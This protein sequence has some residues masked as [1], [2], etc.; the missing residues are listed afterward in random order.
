[1]L[2]FSLAFRFSDLELPL[3]AAKPSSPEPFHSPSA[4]AAWDI[5]G[6]RA[7]ITQATSS[8]FITEILVDSGR[9]AGAKHHGAGRILASSTKSGVNIC[10]SACV[11]G[12]LRPVVQHHGVACLGEKQPAL[13]ENAE[14]AAQQSQ[15]R[16]QQL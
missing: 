1:M 4:S 2:K 14:T 6:K 16:N 9:G 8:F 3:E 13:H 12:P 10:K 11:S 5:A 7:S 15:P